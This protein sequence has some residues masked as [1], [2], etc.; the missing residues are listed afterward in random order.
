MSAPPLATPA[1][2]G[3]FL[4]ETIASDD[5]VAIQYLADASAVIRDYLDMTVTAVSGDV[6]TRTPLSGSV[7]LKESPIKAITLLE[8]LDTWSDVWQPVLTSDYRYDLE[9][10]EVWRNYRNHSGIRWSDE[11]KSWR[12]TYDHGFDTVPDDLAR[13]CYSL[14]GRFYATP[15]GVDQERQGQ[16]QVKYSLTADDLNSLERLTLD[17]YKHARAS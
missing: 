16:R 17:R 2:L 12:V 7:F 15:A 4:Q 10:G 1:Q 9:T 3:N 5:P 13:V 14:A 6:E 11:R 8:V